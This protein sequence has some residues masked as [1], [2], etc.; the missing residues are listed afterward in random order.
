MDLN[1]LLHDH[2]I[3][4][5]GQTKATTRTARAD[6]AD[7]MTLLA[8]RIRTLREQAGVDVSAAPFVAGEPIADYRHR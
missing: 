5:F 1:K 7:A 6:H 8:T 4:K 2:Q 3:A